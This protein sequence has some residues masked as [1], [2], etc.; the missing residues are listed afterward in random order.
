MT[1]R[2][3]ERQYASRW[4]AISDLET[5]GHIA[6][7]LLETPTGGQ[8]VL[9]AEGKLYRDPAIPRVLETGMVVIYAR[10]FSDADDY[11]P[12]PKDWVPA[13]HRPLHRFLLERRRRHEAHT[14]VTETNAHRRDVSPPDKDGW[15][16][17]GW[18]DRLSQLQLEQLADLADK[19]SSI[20]KDRLEDHG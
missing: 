10:I 17:I 5:V 9:Q 16:M 1:D 20:V 6:H 19:L 2:R 15:L 4:L 18:P 11:S 14:D 7:V 8:A 3:R 13:Q 12:I